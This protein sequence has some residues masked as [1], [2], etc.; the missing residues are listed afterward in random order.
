MLAID[1]SKQTD[2]IIAD[3]VKSEANVFRKAAARG[4]LSDDDLHFIATQTAGYLHARDALDDNIPIWVENG[5]RL[6]HCSSYTVAMA[7]GF[8]HAA[9][10]YG[11]SRSDAERRHYELQTRI[12]QHFA[13]A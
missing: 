12:I 5:E 1:L 2:I 6:K 7:F 8:E 3:M 13:G 10:V 11:I 4:V 9:S